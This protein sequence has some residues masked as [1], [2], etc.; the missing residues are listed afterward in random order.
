[1]CPTRADGKISSMPSRMP[2]PARMI[3][4][5][6]VFLPSRIGA[7]IGAIG[8]SI[9]ASVVGKSRHTSYARSMLISRSRLRNELVLV[10]FDRI[11]DSLC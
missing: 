8:V 9:G 11:S 7:I 2:L 3:E 6:T 5:S 4:T 10:S 1:M